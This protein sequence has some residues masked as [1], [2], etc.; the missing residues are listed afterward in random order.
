MSKREMKY[1]GI[2]WIG[3]IPEHWEI[4]RVKYLFK[5]GRGRIISEIELEE[6]GRYP[7]YS[8]Q[9]KDDG[10]MGYINTYDFDISQ[11]TWTT[12]GVYAGTVFIR[13]GKHNCTNV[14]GTL[15]PINDFN[16]LQYIK[17]LLEM[18]CVYHRRK[19][20]NGGKIM[21]NEMAKIKIVLPPLTEQQKIADFLDKKCKKIDLLVQDIQCQ[22][23]TLEEYKKSV[24]TET[25]T[26]GLNPNVKMKDSGIEWIG[27]IPEE[28]R[29]TRLRYLGMCQNGISKS[30]DCFGI[31]FPFINYSDVY[32]NYK[33]P[34]DVEGLIKS[35][36][37]D[38]I[39]YSVKRGDVLFTRTSETIEEI[40]YAST[41]L[42]NI[43]KSVFAGFLIRFRPNNDQQLVPEFSKYY[44]RSNMHRKYFV[45]EMNIVTR[46]SLSQDLLKNLTV[47]LPSLIEQQQIADYLDKKC[48]EIDSIISAKKEQLEVLQEYKKSL[49]Y[50]Y[51]TG[52]KEV[53]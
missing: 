47:L 17:Y 46:A 4:S 51:V 6:N 22:I 21:N 20:I 19:D 41:C 16:N 28:W 32:K 42:K 35:T 36:P 3:D 50:E 38:R 11:L 29:I 13:H 52:K 9:T 26:K 30:S 25:V 8:S 12:D 23:E 24:I 10:C 53:E 18:I 33:L 39:L 48:E 27:E 5:I 34:Y 37:S 31:G 7:V 44:F 15:Q 45:K 40:G 43:E 49:I 1:S 2:K 14:C